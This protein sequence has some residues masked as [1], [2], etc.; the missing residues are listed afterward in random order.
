MGDNFQKIQR[1]E[2]A[3]PVPRELMKRCQQCGE[4]RDCFWEKTRAPD[5]LAIDLK[6]YFGEGVIQFS[7]QLE[8][9]VKG[10]NPKDVRLEFPLTWLLARYKWNVP[11]ALPFSA[12]DRDVNV[13]IANKGHQSLVIAPLVGEGLGEMADTAILSF[14]ESVKEGENY[15][16]LRELLGNSTVSNLSVLLTKDITVPP[17]R[18]GTYSWLI[19]AYVFPYVLRSDDVES[20]LSNVNGVGREEF[21]QIAHPLE[22]DVLLK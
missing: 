6:A 8:A 17:V 7:H 10:G 20:F 9:L 2:P 14:H 3:W 13:I 1:Q 5:Q 16:G 18:G 21:L 11:T 4:R 22:A 12:P 15:A 19:S